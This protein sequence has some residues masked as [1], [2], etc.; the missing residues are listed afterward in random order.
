VVSQITTGYPTDENGR[1]YR[2]RRYVPA[3][4]T[5]VVL[6]VVGLIVWA[7]ALADSDNQSAPTDCNQPTPASSTAPAPDAGN[8]A[9][10]TTTPPHLNAVSRTDMLEV[11]P[12]PLS[13]FQVR[14]LNASAE[15]GAAR[16]V[17]DDL[18]GQGFSPATDT[19]YGDDALYPNRDLNCVA[20]IRF[21]PAGRAGAA[22][23]WL[24]FPCAQLVDD[25]RRGSTVDVALGEYYKNTELPQDTQ[26]ALE[27]LRSADPKKPE[28]GVDPALL[29]A[30]HSAGC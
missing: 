24:A 28:T 11:A 23:V 27:V 30:V 17:S 5:V 6:L 21:G 12:A 9:P 19:A 2:R 7:T 25:G 22:S 10:A 26:A 15:R 29:S 1:A 4:V 16:T 3:I 18:A 8:P 13:T 20:Q 14:V